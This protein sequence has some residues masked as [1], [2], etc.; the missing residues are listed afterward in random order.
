M[1]KR[2]IFDEKW[3]GN[4]FYLAEAASGKLNLLFGMWG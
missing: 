2:M 3:D 1:R 4:E